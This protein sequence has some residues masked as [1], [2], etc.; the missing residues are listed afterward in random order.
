M[1]RDGDE[2]T[3]S[4]N[5]SIIPLNVLVIDFETGRSLGGSLAALGGGRAG[6][7]IA[8]ESLIASGA[9]KPQF[10]T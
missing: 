10:P 3:K 4:L 9:V 2:G 6:F 8:D 1:R 7:W 5:P